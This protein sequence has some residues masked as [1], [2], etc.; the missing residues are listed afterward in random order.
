ML[1]LS[2]PLFIISSFPG[3]VCQ[4]CQP[5][6]GT[7]IMPEMRRDECEKRR[8]ANSALSAMLEQESG[9]LFT[10]TVMEVAS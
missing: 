9:R 1:L 5:E 3:F 4:I 7:C 10:S 6:Q 8:G 2:L